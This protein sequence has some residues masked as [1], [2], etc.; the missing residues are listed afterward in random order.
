LSNL[1]GADLSG[2]IITN[3]QIKSALTDVKTKL[4]DLK[5]PLQKASSSSSLSQEEIP[6]PQEDDVP[7]DNI[8]W[9]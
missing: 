1:R 7:L 2:E 6:C 4:I 8:N 9:Y 5:T 3:E